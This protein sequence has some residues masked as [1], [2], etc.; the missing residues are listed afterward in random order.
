MDELDIRPLTR[1]VAVSLT[2]FTTDNIT[3]PATFVVEKAL[4]LSGTDAVLSTQ[5][6]TV[7]VSAA[8]MMSLNLTSAS[9]HNSTVDSL[10]GTM[11]ANVLISEGSR[12]E[13]SSINLRGGSGGGG[14]GGGACMAS[15]S[16]DS[17]LIVD[18]LTLDEKS[19][20]VMAMSHSTLKAAELE[21]DGDALMVSESMAT[22]G[23]ATIEANTAL[24]KGTESV[25][26]V[27]D[28]DIRATTVL[29]ERAE[30]SGN[31]VTMQSKNEDS[32]LTLYLSHEADVKV[33]KNLT[34]PGQTNVS[35]W[36]Q[37]AMKDG[38]RL[39]VADGGTASL[40][41]S[42][43]SMT[44]SSVLVAKDSKI[45]TSLF[46]VSNGSSLLADAVLVNGSDTYGCAFTMAHDAEAD[47]TSLRIDSNDIGAE[48]D[49]CQFMATSGSTYNSSTFELDG[50]S[51][52]VSDGATVTV[53]GHLKFSGTTFTV[54]SATLE[55]GTARVSTNML[56]ASGATALVSMDEL[57]LYTGHVY[58]TDSAQLAFNKLHLATKLADTDLLLELTDDADVVIASNFTLPG[59]A[60]A[61]AMAAIELSSGAKLRALGVAS[62]D[63]HEI[64]MD[65]ASGLY[66][67]N[68]TIELSYLYVA[69][70]ATLVADVVVVE[71]RDAWPTLPPSPST[72][73]APT[74]SSMPS[75]SPVPSF[76]PSPLPSMLPTLGTAAPTLGTHAP[77]VMP[78][79]TCLVDLDASGSMDATSLTVEPDPA[80]N[81]S[82]CTLRG[83][84]SASMTLTDA[85]LDLG[86]LELTTAASVGVSG[87][88]DLVVTT[89]R[90]ASAASLTVDSAEARVLVTSDLL[91]ESA[92]TFSAAEGAVMLYPN[93]TDMTTAALHNA[94]F[95]AGNL[96]MV[97]EL[98]TRTSTVSAASAVIFW[99]TVDFHAAS[100][101]TFGNLALF[102]PTDSLLLDMSTGTTCKV[103]SMLE[104]MHGTGAV[105]AL[106]QG[107][108]LLSTGTNSLNVTTVSLE[109]DSEL[110]VSDGTLNAKLV[111][112]INSTLTLSKP[113]LT[114]TDVRVEDASVIAAHDETV[115]DVRTFKVRNSTVNAPMA[116]LSGHEVHFIRSEANLGDVTVTTNTTTGNCWIKFREASTVSVASLTLGERDEATLDKCEYSNTGRSTFTAGMLDVTVRSM[117]EEATAV[118]T[119]DADIQASTFEVVEGADFDVAGTWTYEGGQAFTV[120]AGGIFAT[121]HYQMAVDSVLAYGNV[122]MRHGN[123]TTV[124]GLV[125]GADA[126]VHVDKLQVCSDAADSEIFTV[127]H[128]VGAF[129]ARDLFIYGIENATAQISA[130]SISRQ[131]VLRAGGFRQLGEFYCPRYSNYK[132]DGDGT[133][134]VD[135][136]KRC[137]TEFCCYDFDVNQTTPTCNAD[138]L[139]LFKR[140]TKRVP[141]IIW[142]IVLYS[143]GGLAVIACLGF[144]GH[145]YRRP[146]SRAS[147]ALEWD[148]FHREDNKGNHF[149]DVEMAS[150]RNPMAAS[151]P[152]AGAASGSNPMRGKP[153]AATPPSDGGAE[154]A[155]NPMRA[156]KKET[157]AQGGMAMSSGVERSNKRTS[158]G[159]RGSTQRDST[160]SERESEVDDEGDEGGEASFDWDA[161]GSPLER[162]SSMGH[163]M[164]SALGKSMHAEEDESEEEEEER[165]KTTVI[166]EDEEEEW[167]EAKDPAS[168]NTYYYN[169][170]GDVRWATQGS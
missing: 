135:G 73:L 64:S 77:T 99:P 96:T 159:L 40:D 154:G 143:V 7:N 112:M 149:K 94:T 35:A 17:T 25:V 105:F 26:T 87:A 138:E 44:M 92:A 155:T 21:F 91:M 12:L 145:Q 167:L 2:S 131:F 62:V 66:A 110:S 59:R 163:S 140:S 19:T 45:S 24:V 98:T 166:E 113:T 41:V 129:G 18:A 15:I 53:H 51:T 79:L 132:R 119:K 122:S 30:L 39:R 8:G 115:M 161:E 31:V 57:A 152:M 83:S 82:T 10:T 88:A 13:M 23:K 58:A 29:V 5:Y 111:K 160:T 146:R 16:S 103:T 28:L 128:N 36:A 118:V 157:R 4:T 147:M 34:L 67:K 1:S 52:T 170:K 164:G 151:N 78:T 86:E 9:L 70:H 125:S 121:E 43:I 158:T 148:H 75:V 144:I 133:Q 68:S 142:L 93:E 102:S 84:D 104:A 74:T 14:G 32:R 60:N 120:R 114:V 100:D 76:A 61:T 55:V 48:A 124:S 139:P 150:N 49:E 72:T 162:G 123:A 108:R 101:L 81:G 22:V 6:A 85:R 69:D 156:G 54:D 80:R 56:A 89:A 46:S 11:H 168:G 130:G 50:L 137:D 37:V 27:S 127:E 63:V 20:C 97:G 109:T 136:D 38:A 107:A 165:G 117:V 126:Y 106:T 169:T 116:S 33:A 90:M 95:A 71:P 153:A 65:S 141:G 42:L 134:W 47:L 3:K